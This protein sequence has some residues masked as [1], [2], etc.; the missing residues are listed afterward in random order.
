MR[1]CIC[2]TF[3]KCNSCVSVCT[4]GCVLK[5]STLDA[6]L[7]RVAVLQVRHTAVAEP[8]VV[9]DMAVC[10]INAPIRGVNG[11]QSEISFKELI[12]I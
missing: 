12:V 1:K 11:L 10:V 9:G 6:C 8:Y 3:I 2:V 4:P 7:S 5:G